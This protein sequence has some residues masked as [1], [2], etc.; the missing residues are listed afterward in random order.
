MLAVFIPIKFYVVIG[1]DDTGC[2]DVN[3]HLLA[4]GIQPEF[5]AR[6]SSQAIRFQDGERNAIDAI[7]IY[8][9]LKV[10]LSVAD[11]F[12]SY[13]GI[14]ADDHLGLDRKPAQGH[15]HEYEKVSDGQVSHR[16]KKYEKV[17]KVKDL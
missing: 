17:L 13:K 10:F 4:H 14:F 5:V 8:G 2:A 1:P 16:D 12:I 6:F 11:P 7:S 15:K 3:R 9:K